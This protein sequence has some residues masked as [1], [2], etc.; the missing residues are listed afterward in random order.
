VNVWES[1]VAVNGSHED[2]T[3]FAGAACQLVKIANTTGDY[4]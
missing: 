2:D 4:S 3:R 1:L